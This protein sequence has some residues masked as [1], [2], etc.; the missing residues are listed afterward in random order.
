MK[1]EGRKRAGGIQNYIEIMV[2]GAKNLC[3][4][5]GLP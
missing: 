4:S 2:S 3:G 5:Q 1:K